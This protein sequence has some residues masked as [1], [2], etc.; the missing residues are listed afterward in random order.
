[1]LHSGKDADMDVF[2][3][4][5]AL[6]VHQKGVAADKM[7]WCGQQYRYRPSPFFSLIDNVG[8]CQ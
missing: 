5:A 8:R 7:Q 4:A 3:A 2:E 6:L 1:V